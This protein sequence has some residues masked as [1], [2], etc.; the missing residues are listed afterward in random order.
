MKL[1]IELDE[2]GMLHLVE[3]AGWKIERGADKSFV[4]RMGHEKGL[5]VGGY[6]SLEEAFR[7]FIRLKER[8]PK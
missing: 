2:S 4:L 8:R 3:L 1:E 5:C 7:A 6:G